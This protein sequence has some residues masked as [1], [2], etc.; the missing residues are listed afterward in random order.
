MVRMDNNDTVSK[1]DAYKIQDAARA[2]TDYGLLRPH[3]VVPYSTA[4][5]LN[6]VRFY[7][8]RYTDR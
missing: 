1:E 6:T 2:R 3:T 4:Q 5:R 8:V 7:E